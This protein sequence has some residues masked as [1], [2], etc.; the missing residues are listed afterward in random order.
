MEIRG[1][2]LGWSRGFSTSPCHDSTAGFHSEYA[3]NLP[4]QGTSRWE[5]LWRKGGA[6]PEKLPGCLAESLWKFDQSR[7]ERNYSWW[8]GRAN[9]QS[10][11]QG[12]TLM[13]LGTCSLGVARP[14]QA[15]I[16]Q[17]SRME[18]I[19]EKSA[20]RARTCRREMCR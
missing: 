2:L 19:M 13:T 11:G 8:A 6:Y 1:L 7:G 12:Q 18:K 4:W 17:N 9:A 20:T 3:P 15:S 10:R 14:K 16:P 5:A